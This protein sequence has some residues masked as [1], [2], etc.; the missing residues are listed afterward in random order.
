[1]SMKKNILLLLFLSFCLSMAYAQEIKV[2]SF[3]KLERDLSAR[4]K[5]QEDLNGE[6]CSIVKIVTAHARSFIFEGNVVGT[7]I[8]NEGEVWI[9]MPMGSRR[10]T[11]RNDKYG[12]LRYDF[13]E[14][15]AKQGVYEITVKLVEDPEKKVRTLVMPVIGV[16]KGHPTYGLMIGLVRNTGPYLKVKYD[17]SNL[18]TT[19]DASEKGL[20]QNTGQLPWYTGEKKQNRFS[21][22]AG[23]IQRLGKLSPFYLYGGLGY[24]YNKL[25]WKTVDGEWVKNADES[26]SGLEVE[27]GGI[28]R[29]KNFS[30]SLGVQ[31]NSFKYTEATVGV[32]VMF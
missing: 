31:T 13:P 1:M 17:F 18:S 14:K 19:M 6:P 22:T 21:A 9:Y 26:C 27:I 32:G 8:Y 7:P 4:T 24:G 12:V 11:I 28:Y 30:A 2:K 20:I 5:P 25:G 29:Y 23:V 3:T 16:G 10:L 15:L